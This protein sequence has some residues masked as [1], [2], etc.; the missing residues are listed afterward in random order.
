MGPKNTA[1]FYFFKK[2]VAPSVGGGGT[3]RLAEFYPFAAFEPR[4]LCRIGDEMALHRGF[5]R[6]GA[7]IGA[8]EE[9]IVRKFC[10]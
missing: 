7:R 9:G 8:A 4:T 10:M 1:E 2:T 3:K 5:E 6:R